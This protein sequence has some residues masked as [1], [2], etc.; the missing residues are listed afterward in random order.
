MLLKEV[1]EKSGL[2]RKAVQYYEDQGFVKPVK[3]ENG[4]RDYDEDCL[5]TLRDIHAMRQMGLH[6]KEIR[7]IL[8]EEEYAPQVYEQLIH[9]LDMQMVRLQSQRMV[10]RKRMH[11]EEAEMEYTNE[12]CPYVYIRKPS[13]LLGVIQCML[14]ATGF[15][16]FPW[17]PGTTNLWLI[18]L[19]LAFILQLIQNMYYDTRIHG[20]Q[21]ME[22]GWKQL[23]LTAILSVICGVLTAISCKEAYMQESAAIFSVTAAA[24]VTAAMEWISSVWKLARRTAARQNRHGCR[25]LQRIT[26]SRLPIRKP[27][28][29][30]TFYPGTAHS[31]DH[32]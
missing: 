11:H 10:L 22:I 26:I 29:M 8:I 1:M 17:L 23:L 28:C 5:K 19:L 27:L 9:E 12:M 30:Q 18:A 3:L 13:L 6:I 15:L 21:Y 31:P 4:Y 14:G 25:Y 16:L 2:S 7:A 24:A 32:I 20:L